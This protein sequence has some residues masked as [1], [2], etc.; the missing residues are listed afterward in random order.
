MYTREKEPQTS[1]ATA[2]TTA[3]ATEAANTTTAS[4][5]AGAT[6]T[7]TASHTQKFSAAPL[8]KTSG[9]IVYR[10]FS[11]KEYGALKKLSFRKFMWS[12]NGQAVIGNSYF[13]L[14]VK[15]YCLFISV[16][17]MKR[18]SWIYKFSAGL[19]ICS[20]L[21]ERDMSIL[22]HTVA[23]LAI[24]IVFWPLF[25]L[26]GNLMIRPFVCDLKKTRYNEHY[27]ESAWWKNTGILP[28]EIVQ[29]Q[30]VYGEYVATMAA[31]QNMKKNKLHGR[32]FNNVLVP[33]ADGNYSEL[34]VVW[35]NETGIHV[36]EAKA[37]CGALYGSLLSPEWTQVMGQQTH[38][39]KNPFYQNQT[40]I[41]FLANY[42]YEN[43]IS[44]EMRRVT[45]DNNKYINVV[46]FGVYGIED[47]INQDAGPVNA[48]FG[49]YDDYRDR[50][51]QEIYGMRLTCEQV[52]E[53]CALIDTI[54][55][56]N[57]ADLQKYQ[58]QRSTAY[59]QGA[60]RY[61]TSYSIVDFRYGVH[62]ETESEGSTICK[63]SGDLVTFLDTRDNMYKSLPDAEIICRVECRDLNHANLLF[64]EWEQKYGVGA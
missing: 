37:R 35:V 56:Y 42:L 40:H 26:Q 23:V 21:V 55:G 6:A 32:V 14:I 25:N 31:E 19:M 60:Y 45:A 15:L 50:N 49:M 8:P 5:T 16:G 28:T 10:D 54:S 4:T 48:Y 7:S 61:H 18:P 12:P 9:K 27:T 59:E 34:D 41:N 58:L 36:I 11:E 29:D 43:A 39:M 24:L 63:E 51:L 46:M 57:R 62:E 20:L 52:D 30:G 13:G 33:H 38:T 3:N 17:T 47:H 22:L 44:E 2:S 53:I 1:T 64:R